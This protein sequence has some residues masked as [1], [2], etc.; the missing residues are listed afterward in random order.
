MFSETY[1]LFERSTVH[2]N[3]SVFV[4]KLEIKLN[5]SSKHSA[6]TAE[7]LGDTC[8][9]YMDVSISHQH[10]ALQVSPSVK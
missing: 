3:G 6:V 2:L 9:V 1:V 10:S 5:L 7:S 8:R 4:S